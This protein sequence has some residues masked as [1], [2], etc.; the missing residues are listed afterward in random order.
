MH[1][2]ARRIGGRIS[3]PACTSLGRR[4]HTLAL[5]LTPRG[6]I[7]KFAAVQMIDPQVSTTDAANRPS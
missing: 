4:L 6:A 2:A 1:Q 3:S 5:G 7:D